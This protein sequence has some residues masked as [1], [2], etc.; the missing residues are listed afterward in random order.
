VH[1]VLPLHASE[2]PGEDDEVEFAFR[3]LDLVR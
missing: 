2:R 1:D 3:N